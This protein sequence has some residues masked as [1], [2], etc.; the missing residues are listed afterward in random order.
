MEDKSTTRTD[1]EILEDISTVVPEM[2]KL[3]GKPARLLVSPLIMRHI[4]NA[5]H[6]HAGTLHIGVLGVKLKVESRHDM[7]PMELLIR[8]PWTCADVMNAIET[9]VVNL[10]HLLQAQ[11]QIIKDAAEVDARVRVRIASILD[12]I[13]HWTR[14]DALDIC[15]RNNF[16]DA[17]KLVKMLGE[18]Y[19]ILRNE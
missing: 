4:E 12:D 18:V 6:Y 9:G 17:E 19:K 10:E 5:P 1:R 3:G 13:L 2:L 7:P 14:E 11:R 15:M 8:E 16:D